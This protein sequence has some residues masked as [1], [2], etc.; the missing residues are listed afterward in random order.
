MA[1]TIL[2]YYFGFQHH[3]EV[4]ESLGATASCLLTSGR[5]GGAAKQRRALRARI[6]GNS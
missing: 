6:G 5:V 3:V 4:R 1:M 2:S